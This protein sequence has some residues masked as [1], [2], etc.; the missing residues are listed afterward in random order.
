MRVRVR[1]SARRSAL[2]IVAMAAAVAMTAPG[3]AEAARQRA[4]TF[5]PV[6]EA[7]APP[8]GFF[9]FCSRDPSACGDAAELTAGRPIIGEDQAAAPGP[10]VADGWS[11]AQTGRRYWDVV[12]GVAAAEPE[13]APPQERW[14][15]ADLTPAQWREISEINRQVNREIQSVNDREFFRRRDFWSLPSARDGRRYGDC[16]DYV[17]EKRKELIDLGVPAEA[18]SIAIARTRQRQAH[19][20]LLLTTPSGDFVLDNRSAWIS[21]WDE[22]SYRWERRQVAGGHR[23]ARVR[24]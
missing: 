10:A 24:A 23:W 3:S 19:A 11:T 1:E 15:V 22:T 9:D 4:G 13:P 5:M 8:Y 14:V 2:A 20:V 17:L 12:F 6:G 7:V 16:E 18:L 21:R